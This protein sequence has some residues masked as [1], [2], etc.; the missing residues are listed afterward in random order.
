MSSGEILTFL[1]SDD[2]LIDKRAVE[3]MVDKF[4]KNPKSDLVYGDF[5]EIDKDNKFL[6]AYKRPN[7][8]YR[9]LLRI[10]YIS[11]PAT[12]FTK[13]LISKFSLNENL[14]YGLDLELWLKAY[15]AG[16][17]YSKVS[18]F[19]AAERLHDEAKGVGQNAKQS[20]EAKKIR[21]EYGATFSRLHNFLRIIDRAVLYAYRIFGV[22]YIR[23]LTKNSSIQINYKGSIKATISPAS[24]PEKFI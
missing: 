4:I 1:N 14:Q 10:G 3:I 7:F 6:R 19:V 15:V 20:S 18:C 11:Q 17:K 5:I 16:F 24:L 13:D 22:F 9:R 8:S 2:V 21:I 12:F 23:T